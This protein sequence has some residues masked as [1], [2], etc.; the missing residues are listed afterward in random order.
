MPDREL[1]LEYQ[2][3]MQN[4][5]VIQLYGELLAFMREAVRAAADIEGSWRVSAVQPGRLDAS[6]FTV[7]T[8]ASG[9]R[10]GKY[11]VALLHGKLTFELN[12]PESPWGDKKGKLPLPGGGPAPGT[13][14]V[15]SLCGCPL[16]TGGQQP[17]GRGRSDSGKE[18]GRT[19][20]QNRRKPEIKECGERMT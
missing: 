11:V 17:S 9:G 8:P 12:Q 6:Y 4:T 15:D 3:V 5:R 7:V 20:L 10:K 1:L 18:G 16:E 19:D 13:G 2:A 14:G